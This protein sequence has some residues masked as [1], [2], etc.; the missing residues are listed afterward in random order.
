MRDDFFF[1]YKYIFFNFFLNINIIKR[2]LFLTVSLTS[3]LI[4]IMIHVWFD[5]LFITKNKKVSIIIL[6]Y[7]FFNL[8]INILHILSLFWWVDSILGNSGLLLIML[9]FLIYKWTLLPGR[10][11]FIMQWACQNIFVGSI[12][13]YMLFFVGWC[14]RKRNNSIFRGKVGTRGWSYFVLFWVHFS[15][16]QGLLVVWSTFF[17]TRWWWSRIAREMRTY[18]MVELLTWLGLFCCSFSDLTLPL[19]ISFV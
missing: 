19:V 13:L 14:G 1:Q 10:M 2:L 17:R 11:F 8:V 15:S 12:Y 3:P 9:L 16:I 4:S 18:W 7:F 6:F 5:P